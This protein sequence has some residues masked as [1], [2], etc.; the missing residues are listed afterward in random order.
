MSKD[1]YFSFEFP[2]IITAKNLY[3]AKKKL[4][5]E[6]TELFQNDEDLLYDMGLNFQDAENWILT[7][8]QDN[9]NK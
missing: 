6:I 1:Y 3:E 5:T 4:Q 7:E 2:L 8:I 9:T